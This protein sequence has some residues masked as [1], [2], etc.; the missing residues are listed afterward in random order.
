MLADI[1]RLPWLAEYPKDVVGPVAAEG[2]TT[3]PCAWVMKMW[4]PASSPSV[5]SPSNSGCWTR[6]AARRARRRR[7]EAARHAHSVGSVNRAPVCTR[8]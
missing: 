2:N 8:R 3:G 4:V 5:A 1:K 6:A 7:R